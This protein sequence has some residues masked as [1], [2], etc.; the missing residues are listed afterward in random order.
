VLSKSCLNDIVK[1]WK[2][3]L[4]SHHHRTHNFIWYIGKW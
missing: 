3:Q 4:L 2:K 1:Y